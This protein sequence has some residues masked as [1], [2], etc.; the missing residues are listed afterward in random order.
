MSNP[1]VI[2]V[3]EIAKTMDTTLKMY[4]SDVT[5]AIKV[6]TKKSMS[7]LVKETKSTAPRSKNGIKQYYKSIASKKTNETEFDVTYTWYVKG[8]NYRLSHLLEDG[9]KTRRIRNGKEYTRAFKFISNATKDVEKD[10]IKK[11]EEILKN[12]G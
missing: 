6:Q 11:V 2:S 4:S 9:H 3:G 10:F 1:I 5:N 12:G 8:S 7:D